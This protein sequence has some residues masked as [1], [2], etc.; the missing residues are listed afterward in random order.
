MIILCVF[1]VEVRYPAKFTVDISFLGELGV[2]R[3]ASALGLILLI[4]VQLTL[5]CY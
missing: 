2:V 4:G 5:W 1:D 3:H